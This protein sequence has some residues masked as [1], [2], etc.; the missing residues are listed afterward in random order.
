MVT[1]YQRVYFVY[2]SL[3]CGH[4]SSP[5]PDSQNDGARSVLR[6][7]QAICY[8]QSAAIKALSVYIRIGQHLKHQR[9]VDEELDEKEAIRLKSNGN[10]ALH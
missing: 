4:I 10:R 2:A 7:L 8:G 1:F 3:L 5:E 9:N 6:A